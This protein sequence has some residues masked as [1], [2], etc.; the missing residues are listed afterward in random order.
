MTRQHL[1]V[2]VLPDEE[3]IAQNAR[4][5]NLSVTVLLRKI[6]QGYEL[7]RRLDNRRVGALGWINGDHARLGALTTP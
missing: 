4:V 6:G 7:R 5:A 2:S 3:L 1:R